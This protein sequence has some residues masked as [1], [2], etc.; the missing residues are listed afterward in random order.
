MERTLQ[1][2]LAKPNAATAAK[3]AE[4]QHAVKHKQTGLF[5]A[6]FGPAPAYEV[7][8]GSQDVAK[9]MPLQHAR[10]QASLFRCIDARSQLKPVFV[11][12]LA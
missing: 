7:L 1:P 10:C 2:N 5:F 8:W 3:P 11:G 4:A 12:A 9:R 6:G